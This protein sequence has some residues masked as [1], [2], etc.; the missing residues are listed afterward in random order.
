M[1]YIALEIACGGELAEVLTAFLSDWPFESFETGD[2]MLKAYIPASELPACRE[3]VDRLLARYGVEGRYAPIRTCNWNAEWESSFPPVDV[4]GRIRIRAPFHDPAPAGVTEIVVMPDMSFGTGHHPTTWL[5]TRALLHS[6]LS[7]RR[8]LDAGCGTGVLSIV[9]AK[10]GAAQVDAVDTDERACENA[11]ANAAA[12]SVAERIEI[13]AGDVGRVAGRRYDAVLANINRNV[14][15]DAMA[16][17]A[18]ALMPDG[19]LLLSGFY[20]DDVPMLAAAAERAGLR[21]CGTDE[22][23]GWAMIRLRIKN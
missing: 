13:L 17:F 15:I 3:A 19:V 16:A 14:L 4:E 9:A 18:A 21:V 5:M 7:G 10:Y 2:G 6:E 22:R 1:D 20:P 23:E 12:N 11:R 8:V